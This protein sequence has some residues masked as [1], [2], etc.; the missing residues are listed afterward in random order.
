MILQAD[1]YGGKITL[2]E[3]QWIKDRKYKNN[4]IRDRVWDFL[5]RAES[6]TKSI[7][8]VLMAKKSRT[9]LIGTCKFQTSFRKEG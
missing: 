4:I 2:Q 1:V 9:E 5:E 8:P 3:L 6:E 7:F